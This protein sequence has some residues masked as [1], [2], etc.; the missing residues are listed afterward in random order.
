ME[1]YREL[2]E[3]VVADSGYVEFAFDKLESVAENPQNYEDVFL[4]L[5]EVGT[6][7]IWLQLI[8]FLIE[9]NYAFEVD[10][11]AYYTEV[12]TGIEGLFQKKGISIILEQDEDL[13]DLDAEIYFPKI[14]QLLFNTGFSIINLDIDSDSY[15]ITLV[16][17][18]QAEV[19]QSLD[20]RVK[21][22]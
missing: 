3:I 2:L 12:K 22:P 14:N 9:N 20:V 16:S 21:L 19:L 18:S 13:Y 7:L 6:D 11:K 8:D 15:V 17:E 4:R 10:W 1:K 5:P